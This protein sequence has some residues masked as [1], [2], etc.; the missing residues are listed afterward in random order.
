MEF[1]GRVRLAATMPVEF[2]FPERDW[3]TLILLKNCDEEILCARC[4]EKMLL[5][6]FHQAGFF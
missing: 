3:K 1:I 5:L 4:G 2:Y 6:E